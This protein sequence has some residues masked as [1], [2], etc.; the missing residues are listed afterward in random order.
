MDLLILVT[1]LAAQAA[2][3]AGS[4]PP[5]QTTTETTEGPRTGSTSYAD[6]EAGAGYAT[7]PILSQANSPGEG[8]GRIS[9]H[10]VHTRVSARTTTVLYGYAQSLF[11]TRHYGSEQSVDVNARHDALVNEHV[12]VFGDLDASYDRGGQLDTTIIGVP[13]VPPPPGT[14][15]P[16][17]LLPGGSDFLSVTGKQY[18]ESGHIGVQL[19]LS[20]R[21]SLTATGGVEHVVFKSGSLDTN[22][23]TIP[24]SLG[25]SRQINP[26]TSV[27]ARVVAQ[28]TD[29]SGPS[30]FNV[31]SPEA[32]FQT[33]LTER[34]SLS[35]AVGVSFASVD[36]GISTRHSTGLTANANLCSINPRGHLCIVGAID[37]ES[38]TV[39]GPARNIS[40]GADYSRRLNA[41]DT[42]N[43]SL[44]GN[45]YSSPI[46]VITGRTF[47]HATYVRAAGDYT[48][49]LGDRWFGGVTLAARKVTQSGPD[50]DAYISGSLFIRYRLGDVR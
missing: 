34:M 43:F 13:N 31:V 27:G 5:A 14:T 23:T 9:V 29:Y 36:N 24:V 38:A 47:S 19:S 30:S 6:L 44:S 4:T 11:Y 20:P 18:R 12:R 8:F 46:S 26:R 40:V 25:Y 10:A 37:Q 17:L 48:R 2:A 33:N 35:G 39:A 50:P 3:P 7:N 42:I 21:D 49:R 16:P 15:V 22:Y 28:H 1:A 32:T 45:R 41:D